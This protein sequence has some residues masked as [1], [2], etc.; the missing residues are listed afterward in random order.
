[1]ATRLRRPCGLRSAPAQPRVARRSCSVAT[2]RSSRLVLSQSTTHRDHPISSPWPRFRDDIGWHGRLRRPC[3]LRSAPA[4]P[5]VARRSCSVATPRSSRLVLSQSTTHRDHPIPS[6]WPRFRDDIGWHGRL[7]RP[8]GLRSAP[9]QPRV[10]RRSCSV[11]TPRSSRLVP[12]QG[13]H[14]PARGTQATE[15]RPLQRALK[16][17]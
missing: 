13:R 10:A 7:R 2:P 11:A 17:R 5:R 14:T 1:V 8:C 15:E 12:G 9:A 4:Q 6:P 3:G 16:R